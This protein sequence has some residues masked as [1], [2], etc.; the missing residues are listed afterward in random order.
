MQRE[1]GSEGG[2]EVA[3]KMCE[4]VRKKSWMSHFANPLIGF[5]LLGEKAVLTAAL[6]ISS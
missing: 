4:E 6:S 3:K 1:G 2:W 5:Q